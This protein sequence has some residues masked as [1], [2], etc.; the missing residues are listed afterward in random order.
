MS[1]AVEVGAID[2]FSDIAKWIQDDKAAQVCDEIS[3]QIENC[4]LMRTGRF[5]QLVGGCERPAAPA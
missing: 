3:R 5:C 1:H 4:Y 2:K